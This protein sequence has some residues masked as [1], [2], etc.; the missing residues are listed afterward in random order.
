[1]S[2]MTMERAVLLTAGD[3]ASLPEEK[4]GTTEGVT[5][6]VVWRSASGEAGVLRVS[7]RA[8]LGVHAHRA[9]HHHMWVLEGSADILGRRVTAGSYVH[10]PVGTEHDVD[11]TATEGCSVFYLYSR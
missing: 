10:I 6:K 5:R 3:L 2:D 4:L 9:S 8:R 11:A 7:A 1:M